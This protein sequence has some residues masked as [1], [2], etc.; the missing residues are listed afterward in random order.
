MVGNCCWYLREFNI[1]LFLL[2]FS[3][4]VS[5]MLHFILLFYFLVYVCLFLSCILII[6]AFLFFKFYL[7][8]WTSSC[9]CVRLCCWFSF[10]D[11]VFFSL[12]VYFDYI[13]L[14]NKCK[15]EISGLKKIKTK[16]NIYS[17][18]FLLWL[19]FS[20]TGHSWVVRH[21]WRFLCAFFHQPIPNQT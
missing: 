3:V 9:V 11:F 20:L 15:E 7:H 17:L 8:F 14:M 1:W 13:I 4:F 18:W 10:I 2:F 6:I 21:F 19:S 5:E 12:C 16:N